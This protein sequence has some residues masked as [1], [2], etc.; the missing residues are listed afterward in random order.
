MSRGTRARA[1]RSRA[2]HR[3]SARA[4][5][6]PRPRRAR[7]RAGRRRARA[8]TTSSC[9][10][11]SSSGIVGVPSRRSVPGILPVS[12]VWPAQSRMSSAIWNAMP[13]RRRRRRARSSPPE[14]SRHAASISFPVL[15]AHRSRYASIGVV[16]IV[17]LQLL[18]RL[19]A[20]EAERGVGER[21][22]RAL[23]AGLGEHAERARVEVVAGRLRG[24]GAVD[25]PRGGQSAAQPRAVDEV[26]VDERRHVHHL[27]RDAGGDRR[28]AA[29]R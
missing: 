18:H 26:V 16:G 13:R 24:V 12:C 6:S 8:R 7:R 20:R 5:R 25:R 17:R 10:A 21:R 28:L 3:A 1:R 9:A 19:A 15:S 4:R 27:D 2:R 14:P 22:D 29:A 11:A 23:V